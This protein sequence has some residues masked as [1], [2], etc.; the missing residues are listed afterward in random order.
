MLVFG[1]LLIKCGLTPADVNVI[2]H[3]TEISLRSRF[4]WIA[5]EKPELFEYY[6]STQ[7][8]TRERMLERRSYLAS[9]VGLE[10]GETIFVGVY[11]KRSAT[12]LSKKDFEADERFQRLSALGCLSYPEEERLY[13]DFEELEDF[14]I[15]KGRLFIG[16]GEGHRSFIQVPD[17]QKFPITRLSAENELVAELSHPGELMLSVADIR[18]LPMTWRVRISQWRGIYL[19][20]DISDGARYVGA[21]YGSD[22]LWQRWS[23]Y[24]ISGHGGDVLLKTRD[25][26]NFRFSVLQLLSPTEEIDS[27]LA[28]E[29]GWKRRLLTRRADWEFGLNAN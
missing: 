4:P 27:V 19:I 12:R 2:R 21:A 23:E 11:R 16:W 29:A 22:N 25:A 10:N 15:Y 24:S 13:F 8:P 6:Q 3:R 5:S 17:R 28:A 1:D 26:A 18:E 14:R 9:F 20:T 7:S